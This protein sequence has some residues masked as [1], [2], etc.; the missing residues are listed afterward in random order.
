MK[1]I[2]SDL[3]EYFDAPIEEIE[4][5]DEALMFKIVSV[6]R[7]RTP[8]F[9]TRDKKIHINITRGNIETPVI[10]NVGKRKR[11]KRKNGGK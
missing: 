9:F 3:R 7:T 11:G 4:L 2:L 8:I 10:K 6:T 1:G 5:S